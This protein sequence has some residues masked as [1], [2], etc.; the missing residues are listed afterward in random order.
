MRRILKRIF[1]NVP[2]AGLH[3][4]IKNFSP[5]RIND[6]TKRCRNFMRAHRAAVCDFFQCVAPPLQA[7]FRNHRLFGHPRRTRHFDIE[8][9]KRKQHST[10]THRRGH[11]GQK[12]IRIATLDQRGTGIQAHAGR[13]T[14]IR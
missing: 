10:R 6:I 3:K 11:R 2:A 12:S 1:V 8:R 7:H 5:L 4:F 13:T 14:L 9:I